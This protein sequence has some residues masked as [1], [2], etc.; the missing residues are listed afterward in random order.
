[1]GRPQ[2]ALT[3]PLQHFRRSQ[4]RL[5]KAVGKSRASSSI[6]KAGE[7]FAYVARQFRNTLG[8]VATTRPLPLLFLDFTAAAKGLNKW[9]A[10]PILRRKFSLHQ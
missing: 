6:V 1:M 10:A 4:N 9:L 3:P 5:L 2:S 8:G 7:G